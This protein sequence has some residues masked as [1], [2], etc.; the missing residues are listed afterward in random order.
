MNGFSS[1]LLGSDFSSSSESNTMVLSLVSIKNP[2]LGTELIIFFFNGA[3]FP[4]FHS[5]SLTQYSLALFPGTVCLK[6]LLGL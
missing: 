6:N 1:M 3:F 4:G 2:T 5:D